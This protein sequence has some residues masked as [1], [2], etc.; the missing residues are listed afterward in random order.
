MVVGRDEKQVVYEVNMRLII[1]SSIHVFGFLDSKAKDK[2][3]NAII[4]LLVCYIIT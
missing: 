4:Q 2:L 3:Q 1:F